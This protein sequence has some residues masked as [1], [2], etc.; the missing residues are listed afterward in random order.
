MSDTRT[1]IIDLAE[2]M[3]RTGG[4]NGFSFREIAAEIGIKSASVHYHFPTKES[5]ATAVAIRYKQQF[6]EALGDPMPEGSNPQQQIVHYGNAF[7]ASFAESHSACLCGMLSNEI[8]LLPIA[9]KA[10]MIEFVEA[11]IAWLEQALGGGADATKQAKVVYAAL[12]G[13]MS[14]SALLQDGSW[15]DSVTDSIAQQIPSI[16]N[17]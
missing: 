9:V 4:Y 2:H 11:N 6:L 10:I 14:T 8:A 1:Q 7:R 5:L 13:A 3:V 16:N 15:L 17:P 12:E